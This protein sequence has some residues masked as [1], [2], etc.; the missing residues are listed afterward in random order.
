MGIIGNDHSHEVFAKGFY[1]DAD[2]DY[3]VRGV[4]GAA[5]YGASEPGEVLATIAGVPEGKHQKWFGAW[6]ALGTRIH[7]EAEAERAAGRSVSAAGAY[8][9]ACTYLSVAVSA[10]SAL[11]DDGPLLPT[12]RLQKASWDGFVDTFGG[13]VDRVA[14]PYEDTPLP[15]YYFRPVGDGNAARPTVVIVNGSDNAISGLW[16]NGASA[17]LA[18]GYNVLLFDGPGQQSMLFEKNIGFRPDWGPVL[19]P[20]VDFVLTLPGVDPDRLAVYGSSQGGY[21]VADALATERR[22]A[23]AVLDPGVTRVVDSWTDHIPSPLMKLFKEGK[24]ESFDRDMGLGMKVSAATARTW[25]FR[26]RP[27]GGRGYFDTLTAV[28]KYAL[29]DDAIAKI[30]TPLFLT[31]PEHEQFWPGQSEE[32]AA[33]V[34]NGAVVQKFTAAEGADY[35][36]QPLARTLTDVKV[37]AWLENTLA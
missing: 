7:D 34:G 20:V 29:S 30:D 17:A 28:G 21:W 37:F 23:A 25:K 8:L 36:C 5:P 26:A 31:S 15:G 14:I 3:D 35:H 24:Q 19:T 16:T 2:Y 9:R 22:F 12:Y 11:P 27:Y 1:K 6:L 32:L 18:R 13:H 4:L 10:A 33:K